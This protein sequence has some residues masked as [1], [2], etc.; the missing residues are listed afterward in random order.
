M[1]LVFKTVE[2]HSKPQTR[3]LQ[4]M[5]SQRHVVLGSLPG[6]EAKHGPFLVFE[7]SAWLDMKA[8]A[9]TNLRR[10]QVGILYG[11]AHQDG[12]LAWMQISHAFHARNAHGSAVHV[13]LDA[14]AWGDVHLQA[15]E[16]GL[17]GTDRVVVGWWHTHPDL[18]AFFSGTDRATQERAFPRHWQAGVV[19]DP[20]RREVALFRGG[21][22]AP[23]AILPVVV[24]SPA[25]ARPDVP[26]EAVVID[27]PT[28]AQD[29]SVVAWDALVANRGDV[30]LKPLPHPVS[31][32]R[33]ALVFDR[34]LL[35]RRH[36]LAAGAL[37]SSARRGSG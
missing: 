22:S 31:P 5:L 3:A 21:D 14:E 32:D 10:E 2:D 37:K 13:D 24:G 25:P 7:E 17:D 33:C 28:N 29:L 27:L 30:Q 8:A 4:S 6:P 36:P 26:S 18:G 1:S 20:V 11:T 23:I 35:K 34:P 19:I 15:H 12:V 9:R 16:A